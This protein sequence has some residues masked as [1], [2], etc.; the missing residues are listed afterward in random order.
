MREV[1][2]NIVMNAGNAM[3]KSGG[4]LKVSSWLSPRS[5]RST[6]T[7]VRIAFSDTGPGIPEGRSAEIFEPFISGSAKGLGLGLSISQRICKE[8][9]GLISAT[10]NADGG[11]RFTV[12]LPIPPSPPETR[13][14]VGEAETSDAVAKL[15][16]VPESSS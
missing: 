12:I 3:R 9:G 13:S 4:T 16:V 1:F 10:N 6:P 14:E 11:A 5:K 7:G 8:H 2:L 15:E